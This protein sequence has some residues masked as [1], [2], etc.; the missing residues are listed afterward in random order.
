MRRQ[1]RQQWWEPFAVFA[2]IL[3]LF[4]A[5]PVFIH[6]VVVPIGNWMG[7]WYAYWGIS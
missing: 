4:L 6:Y 3:M 2:F 5:M 1:Y 7:A